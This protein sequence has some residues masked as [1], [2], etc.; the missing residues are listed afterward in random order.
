[1]IREGTEIDLIYSLE[2]AA[3]VLELQS[4]EM[5]DLDRKIEQLKRCE[6]LKESEVKDLCLKAMEILVEESNVQRV[7]APVIVSIGE[8][9]A[10]PLPPLVELI[11]PSGFRPEKRTSRVCCMKRVESP[12]SILCVRFEFFVGVLD[13]GFGHTRRYLNCEKMLVFLYFLIL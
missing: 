11:I 5:S 9:H 8:I 10:S 4:A 13:L 3:E 2:I 7:D 6:P 12:S 1:M